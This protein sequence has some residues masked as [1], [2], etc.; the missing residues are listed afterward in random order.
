M[1]LRLRSPLRRHLSIH[2]ATP[3]SPGADDHLRRPCIGVG[4]TWKGSNCHA[5]PDGFV[6]NSFCSTTFSVVGIRE[7][8]SETGKKYRGR[9]CNS[10]TAEDTI[11]RLLSV[12]LV[13]LFLSVSLCPSPLPAPSVMPPTQKSLLRSSTVRRRRSGLPAHAL[14]RACPGRAEGIHPCKSSPALCTSFTTLSA[15]MFGSRPD[16]PSILKRIAAAGPVAWT[17]L[18]FA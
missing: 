10:Y 3:R 2:G 17:M 9:G 16:L 7:N 5:D 18:T 1:E 11:P 14:A 6:E 15:P 4:R 12:I 8:V 13:K